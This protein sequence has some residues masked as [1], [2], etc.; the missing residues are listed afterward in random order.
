[1]ERCND[2]LLDQ[3]VVMFET[4]SQSMPWG[5]G[6]KFGLIGIEK[7]FLSVEAIPDSLE[8]ERGCLLRWK[9]APSSTKPISE[10]MVREKERNRF[11]F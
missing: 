1:M 8:K 9:A 11:E 6:Q 4:L 3:R 5:K 2:I 10:D 7:V